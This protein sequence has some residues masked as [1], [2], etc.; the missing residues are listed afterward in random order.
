MM[1]RSIVLLALSAA[2]S[3]LP[4]LGQMRSF[5]QAPVG[6]GTAAPAQEVVLRVKDVKVD[7]RVQSPLYNNNAERGQSTQKHWLRV[8][9]EYETQNEWIDE[10]EF[11]YYVLIRD[12]KGRD[13]AFR[14]TVSYV[15]IKKGRHIADAFIR[16]NTFERMNASVVHAAVVI[17]SKGIAGMKVV[18][19][20]STLSQAN[21]WEQIPSE[22]GTLLNRDETP[23]ANV[24]Y[25]NYELIK[26]PVPQMR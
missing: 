8:I 4:A 13:R 5:S 9:Q 19:S 23:F 24:A 15:D 2:L 3:A 12:A 25:D 26:L 7:M 14:K 21:W 16:P 18:A 17:K 20:S 11:T 22:E 6:G 10:L 1:N